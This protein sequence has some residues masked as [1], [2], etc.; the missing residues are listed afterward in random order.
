MLLN[1]FIFKATKLA[2]RTGKLNPRENTGKVVI[3]RLP[4]HLW[5]QKRKEPGLVLFSKEPNMPGVEAHTFNPSTWE[6][7][8]GGF[9][10]SRPAWSTK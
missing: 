6:A 5:I 1:F 7:E 9:L 8:A 2:Y 10:S 3:Q 4:A